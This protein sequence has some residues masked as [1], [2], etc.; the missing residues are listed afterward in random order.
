MTRQE[1]IQ[2]GI[3]ETL[4]GF[5]YDGWD[6]LSAG[7]RVMWLSRAEAVMNKE[8]SQGVA[9]KTDTKL[10]A[11]WNGKGE[12]KYGWKYRSEIEKAGFTTWDSLVKETKR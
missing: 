12:L 3:A 9:I 10:P 8:H 11:I 6:M 7:S 5:E 4:Y 2:E 1:E